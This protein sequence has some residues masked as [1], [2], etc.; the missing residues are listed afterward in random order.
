MA[1]WY[2]ET[3]EDVSV[4]TF[5]KELFEDTDFVTVVD[6]YPDST[7][8]IPTVSV[9]QGET[10]LTEYEMGN[11]SGRRIRQYI[12]NVF[13][14]NK[15]QRDDY[16]YRIVNALENG[17]VVYNYNEGF[18]SEG[19]TPTVL[20]HLDV[21]SRRIIPIEVLPELVEKLYFRSAVK[22]VATNDRD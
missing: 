13:A 1:T 4:L 19:V 12:I 22:F 17:I 7:L 2:P 16:S 5:I 18:P 21:V 9:E 20:E 3:K 6:E 10:I 14:A 15:S 8:T 11:R